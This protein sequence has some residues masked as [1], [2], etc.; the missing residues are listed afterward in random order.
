[1]S[2]RAL[3]RLQKDNIPVLINDSGDENNYSNSEKE[4]NNE[5]Y[6]LKP[7]ARNKNKKKKE[8]VGNRFDLVKYSIC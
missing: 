5:D 3:R 6:L 7:R 2:S 1:M 4:L 8:F